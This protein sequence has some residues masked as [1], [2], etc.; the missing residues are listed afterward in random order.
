MPNYGAAEEGNAQAQARKY[1][2]CASGMELTR[3]LSLNPAQADRTR[4]ISFSASFLLSSRLNLSTSATLEEYL[5]Q[6][7]LANCRSV[8]Y[9]SKIVTRE[10]F[11]C[12]YIHTC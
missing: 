7:R 9:M 5:W 4:Y 8:I 11:F 6:E 12:D 2:L 1:A 3:Q 10:V